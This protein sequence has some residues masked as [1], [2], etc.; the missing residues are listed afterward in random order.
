[1]KLR[2]TL[3][4]L[5]LL[6]F[7]LNYANEFWL[8]D[9]YTKITGTEAKLLRVCR[10]FLLFRRLPFYSRVPS[11]AASPDKPFLISRREQNARCE[12]SIFVVALPLF[13]PSSELQKTPRNRISNL[14]FQFP[15]INFELCCHLKQFGLQ[16]ERMRGKRFSWQSQ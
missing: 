12:V 10:F 15:A 7:L 11:R 14:N 13:M 3:L 1:M 4:K 9:I 16:R 5:F 2:N 8:L 6:I